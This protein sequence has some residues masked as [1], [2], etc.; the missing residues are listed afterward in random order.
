MLAVLGK[1]CTLTTKLEVPDG[2]SAKIALPFSPVTPDL[3]TGPERETVAPL[4]GPS[5]YSFRT[6]T[7]KEEA[8]EHKGTKKHAHTKIT[9][10]TKTFETKWRF[11]ITIFFL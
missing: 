6:S 7:V 2:K 8:A 1:S 9:E 4:I 10:K 11:G 5:V 3:E